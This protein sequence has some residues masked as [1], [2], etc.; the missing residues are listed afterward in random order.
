MHFICYAKYLE[1]VDSRSP[2]RL[3]KTL[4]SQKDDLLYAELDIGRN[5]R[6]NSL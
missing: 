2:E 3:L 5:G 1:I 6:E 4:M